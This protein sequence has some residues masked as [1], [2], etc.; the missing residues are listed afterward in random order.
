MKKIIN[1]NFIFKLISLITKFISKDIFL[2]KT[3]QKK[4]LNVDI[5]PKNNVFKN[6]KTKSILKIGMLKKIF[7]KVLVVIYILNS[8]KNSAKANDC[9][10]R[11]G[12][13]VA[14]EK[15]NIDKNKPKE[16]MK[17]SKNKV[18]KE[19]KNKKSFNK[20][21][22]KL[23]PC[24]VLTAIGYLAYGKIKSKQDQLEIKLDRIIQSR[25]DEKL[26]Y[27]EFEKNFK[28]DYD[29]VYKFLEEQSK[30][31]E[32]IEN[33]M[34]IQSRCVTDADMLNAIFKSLREYSLLRKELIIKENFCGF[35]LFDRHVH[36]P[37]C[38]Y[39]SFANGQNNGN[40][41]KI[42]N[43]IL[44]TLTVFEQGLSELLNFV[45]ARGKIEAMT[46]KYFVLFREAAYS[47][48]LLSTED[49]NEKN[50]LSSLIEI[51]AE[52]SSIRIHAENSS[53]KEI[54]EAID[55]LLKII[56]YSIAKFKDKK[57]NVKDIKECFNS[58]D[59]SW[60]IK[61]YSSFLG[62]YYN[63]VDNI[64]FLYEKGL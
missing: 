40:E 54:T 38:S 14:R 26:K 64:S 18:E 56:K 17:K 11:S 63:F 19:N 55:K 34:K 30:K 35:Y 44:I 43:K 42:I 7:I 52:T 27:L 6:F 58:K 8:A 49:E 46:S 50:F 31:N 20:T 60:D 9:L 13:L 59:F 29:S 53:F 22:E 33:L 25:T 51:N 48:F 28:K 23:I 21:I 47:L 16:N 10:G 62:V 4:S 36:M 3:N 39:A 37:I 15:K 57:N 32:E 12:Q 2:K 41:E 5:E 24:F 1:L 45:K 61:N